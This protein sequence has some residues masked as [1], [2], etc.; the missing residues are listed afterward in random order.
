MKWPYSMVLKE[1]PPGVFSKVSQ[2]F[3]QKINGGLK[4]LRGNVLIS[5]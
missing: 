3:G 4:F 2:T 5:R 1:Y